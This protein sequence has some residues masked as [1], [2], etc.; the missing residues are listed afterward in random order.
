MPTILV[1]V[2]DGSCLWLNIIHGAMLFIGLYQHEPKQCES[3]YSH[4]YARDC[5]AR[6]DPR[7]NN[8]FLKHLI[9]NSAV[10]VKYSI[11]IYI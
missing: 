6:H 8:T 2:L 9:I 11:S 10:Y 5:F 4:W 7:H 3:I 1:L